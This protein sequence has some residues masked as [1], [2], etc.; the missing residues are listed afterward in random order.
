MKIIVIYITIAILSGGA[1][2]MGMKLLK[3][4]EKIT[5]TKYQA[6]YDGEHINCNKMSMT[7]NCA[8][9]SDCDDK[10]DY[11]CVHNVKMFVDKK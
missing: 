2:Y 3:E 5:Y 9:L 1:G 6:Y 7:K 10:N 8:N 11:L 4:Q